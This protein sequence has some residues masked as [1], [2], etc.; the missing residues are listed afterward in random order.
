[1]AEGELEYEYPILALKG[2]GRESR[3]DELKEGGGELATILPSAI[4][5]YVDHFTFWRKAGISRRDFV[6]K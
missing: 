3:R 5:G 6:Y 1:M 4:H 2:W